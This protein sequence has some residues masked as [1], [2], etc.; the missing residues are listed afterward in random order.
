MPR[1]FKLNQY[2][3]VSNGAI[4]SNNMFKNMFDLLNAATGS[5]IV[6]RL[7]YN[8]GSNAGSGTGTGYWDEVNNFGNNAWALYRFDSAANRTWEWYMLIQFTSASGNFG[9]APGNPGLLNGVAEFNSSGEGSVG[10]SAA[11]MVTSAGSTA[12]PWNGTT[13]NDGNDV[14]GDPVWET[15]SPGDRLS[16]LPRSNSPDGSHSSSRENMVRV[17]NYNGSSLRLISHMAVTEYGFI[18]ATANPVGNTA[19]YT[20]V[21][22]YQ[23]HGYLSSSIPTPL[24]MF[25][26]NANANQIPNPGTVIGNS[27]GTA[28]IEG[29]ATTPSNAVSVTTGAD[30]SV[31]FTTSENRHPSSFVSNVATFDEQPVAIF[32]A[33]DT[34]SVWSS[35]GHI[36]GDTA[37]WIFGCGLFTLSLNGERLAV[38]N[39]TGGTGV[40]KLSMPWHPNA[41]PHG[42]SK[43]REGEDH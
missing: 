38:G 2:T 41:H 42:C 40:L 36:N 5:G 27:T 9:D 25:A 11:A 8:T 30:T 19:T 23:P 3:P 29:G 35:L 18:M 24:V 33:D 21:G 37:R 12:N 22:E 7:A 26:A 10:I 13:L 34:S 14:K 17:L 1:K 32:A 31:Q 28:T 39:S 15:L 20:F 43:T 16:V 6:T 4:G